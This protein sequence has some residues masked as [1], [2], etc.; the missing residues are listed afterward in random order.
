MTVLRHIVLVA[1]CGLTLGPARAPA[2]GRTTIAVDATLGTGFG[3]GGEFFDRNLTGGRVAASV[4]HFSP[5]RLGLFGE[6]ALDALSLSSGHSAVCYSNPR[7]GCLDSYPELWGPT[8]TGGLVAQLT[9]R[10]EMRFGVGAGAYAA[11]GTRVGA[12]LSQFDLSLFPVAHIG[13]IAGARWIVVPR[14][15]GDRLSVLPW[16]IGLRFR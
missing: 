14:Y 3:K 1:V 7:G 15:R 8:V 9:D 5:T 10:I 4:R 16:A 11:T 12:A 6:V 13:L 2:Q